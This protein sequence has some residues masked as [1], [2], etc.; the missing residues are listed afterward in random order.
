MPQFRYQALDAGGRRVRG[1]VTAASPAQAA[2]LLRSRGFTVTE[3]RE[4][5]EAPAQPAAKERRDLLAQLSLVRQ[6]EV[7]LCLKQLASLVRAGVSLTLS[8]SVLEKQTK[9]RKLRYILRQVREAVEG[10]VPLSEAMAR[11]RVF[12]RLV[13]SLVRTGEASGLLDVSLER[14]TRYWEERLA[15][16]RRIISGIIYP[17]LVFVA[18]LGAAIF[19]IAYVIPR[20][21]P[22]LQEIGGELPWNT[23]LLIRIGEVVPPNLPKI[24]LGTAGFLVFLLV[25][26]RIPFLRYYLDRYKIYLP[27]LGEIFQYALVVH[28]AKTMAL[29]LQSG[30]SMIESLRATKETVGNL[31]LQRILERIEEAVLAGE[32]LST[33]LSHATSIFPPMVGSMVRVGEE[34]GGVDGALEML[35]GVYQELLETKIERALSLIEPLLIVLMGGM[36]AFVAAALIGAILASYGAMSHR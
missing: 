28:F 33:P 34:T 23:Q 36:V 12:P 25:A 18:A 6:G 24:G 14:A 13:T 19:L 15:L 1:E 7:L 16:Q 22:F 32:S 31:A 4:V 21:L 2:A 26:L 5:E 29:L 10:G 9:S 20:L 27:V 8:L 17:A 30:V 35:A 3:L 11:H